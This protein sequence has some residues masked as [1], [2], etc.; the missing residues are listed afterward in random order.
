MKYYNAIQL[1]R[2]YLLG[3][4]AA[5]EEKRVDDWYNSLDQAERS[6]S[7]D[8]RKL[9]KVKEEIYKK[10]KTALDETQLKPAPVIPLHRRISLP[11]AAVL[12]AAVC[13]T[14]FFI[15]KTKLACTRFLKLN[16]LIKMYCRN[17]KFITV[18]F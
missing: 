13:T 17:T 11:A 1:L 3:K 6:Q 8:N 14:A 18:C 10:I 7:F 15:F 12:I 5:S 9:D 16:V 2:K 4:V